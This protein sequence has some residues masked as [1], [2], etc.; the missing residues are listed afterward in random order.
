[1]FGNAYPD[2][3]DSVRNAMEPGRGFMHEFAI[4][5][6]AWTLAA[7]GPLV[8]STT[9]IVGFKAS[10]TS[11]IGMVWDA[12][13]DTGDIVSYNGSLPGDFVQIGG[14][15]RYPS[16]TDGPQFQLLVYARKL[17]T[18]G[19]AADNADL[20]LTGDLYWLHSDPDEAVGARGGDQ[21]LNHLT[22]KATALLD[23]LAADSVEQAY[24]WYVLDI[25]ARLEAETK[26]LKP[27]S[28]FRLDLAP[29]DTVGTALNIEVIGTILRYRRHSA[30]GVRSRRV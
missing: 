17:D 12:G 16:A 2:N 18:T 15:G 11:M 25:G 26:V 21:A 27:Y 20:R 19:S 28:A 1:M 10:M 24:H 5:R 9:N 8:A 13:A 7:G 23:T 14:D 4:P 29:D 6:P 22:T 30:L 3:F